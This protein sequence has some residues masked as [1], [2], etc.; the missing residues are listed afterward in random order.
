MLEQN[1]Y[2][3]LSNEELLIEKTKLKRNNKIAIIVCG[4]GVI[5]VFVGIYLH[6]NR[7]VFTVFL[8]LGA[9][10]FMVKYGNELKKLQ[11]E[12]KSRNDL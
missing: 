3:N 1:N 10:F 9:L 12:I 8:I 11:T 2:L 4:L 7:G 5:N 6:Q